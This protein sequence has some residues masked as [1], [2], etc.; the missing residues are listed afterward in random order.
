[1]TNDRR[2]A[3]ALRAGL[4]AALAAAGLIVAA[5]AA[6]AQVQVQALVVP[7]P[8]AAMIVPQLAFPQAD[9]AGDAIGDP[10]WDEA[11]A[12]PPAAEQAPDAEAEDAE[13]EEPADAQAMLQAQLRAQVEMLGQSVRQQG[14]T[15]LRRELSLVRQT[16]PALEKQ[17]RALV[18]EAGRGAIDRAVDE[19]TRA[20]GGR[21]R[22]AKRT[23]L[24]A[25][26]RDALTAAV[27]AN[28]QAAESAAYA[29][30][31][32]LRV[33]RRKAAVVATLVAEVDREAYLDAAEREA[34]AKVLTESYRERWRLAVAALQQNAIQGGRAVPDESILPGLERCVEKALGKDRKNTWVAARDE[35][36]ALAGAAGGQPGAMAFGNG[37]IWVQAQDFAAPGQPGVRRI[38]RRQVQVGGGGV[39]VQV[40]VRAGAVEVDEPAAEVD[41][42]APAED[43][44]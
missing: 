40:E 12:K 43:E 28:A 38:I 15:I 13:A 29:A 17:Q 4:A 33:E 41:E 2:L 10:W 16:C 9:G 34:L 24:E 25:A 6:V 39:Q 37:G 35:A 30:E 27:Q 11:E 44:K 18:L 26:I 22:P 5:T 14:L 32:Q 42:N 36:R 1:M 20:A 21:R 31:H 8:Q 19:Q 7:A 23:D 3:S